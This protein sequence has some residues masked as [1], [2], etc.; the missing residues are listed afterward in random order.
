MSMAA[1]HIPHGNTISCC[2]IRSPPSCCFFAVI[3][4]DGVESLNVVVVVFVDRVFL[5]VNKPSHADSFMYVV[6]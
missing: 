5:P 6:M 1:A 2:W 3:N 4:V